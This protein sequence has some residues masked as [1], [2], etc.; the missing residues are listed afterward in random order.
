MERAFS[1]LLRYHRILK[2]EKLKNEK[3]LLETLQRDNPEEFVEKLKQYEKDRAEERASLKHR[4]GSK[5]QKRQMIYAKFD[6]RV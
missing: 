1:V 3:K 6:D 2:K 5:Y 4:G